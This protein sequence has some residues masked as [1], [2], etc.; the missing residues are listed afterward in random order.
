[1]SQVT[2]LSSTPPKVQIVLMLIGETKRALL[3][4][5]KLKHF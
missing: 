1:M 5:F 4:Y 3:I 2:D